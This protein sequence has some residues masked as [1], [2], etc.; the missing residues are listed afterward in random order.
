MTFSPVF[1]CTHFPKLT[2]LPSSWPCL[3]SP[4]PRCLPS[5]DGKFVATLLPSYISIRAVDTLD[6]VRTIKLPAD[7][8]EA[9]TAFVWSSAAKRILISGADEIHVYSATEANFHATI[10]NPSSS[11]AKSTFVD[12][13]ATDHEACVCSA[14]GIR[15]SLFNLASSKVVEISN[16]KFYTASSAARGFSFRPHTR[17]LALLTRTLGKDTVSIH[18]PDSREVQRS[19]S[20]DT[21]DAQGLSWAPDG[22]WLVM[23]E[24]ASQGHRVLFF[25]PDGHK[26][27]D[28]SGPLHP[29]SDDVHTRLAAGVKLVVFS[30][31]SRYLAIGDYGRCISVLPMATMTDQ[32]QLIYPLAVEPQDTVQI[33]QEQ[34]D[35]APNGQ[36]P[37]HKFIRA[38]QPVAPAA[39]A[40]SNAQDIRTGP[41]FMLFDCSATLLVVVLEDA[42]STLWIWDISVSEIR[43]VIM[44]HAEI[45]K[46]EWHPVQAEL[47]LVECEGQDHVGV[48]FAWDPLSE[49]P[50]TVDFKAQLPQGKV[51]GRCSTHWLRN[52]QGPASLF[53]TDSK[54]Y[55]LATVVDVDQDELPWIVR[56]PTSSASL[57]RAAHSPLASAKESDGDDS[58]MDG[59]ASR[60]DDTFQFKKFGAL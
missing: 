1:K 11:I 59:D 39:R 22:K 23:W 15:L 30:P 24:S 31:D 50:R 52:Q 54:S 41:L 34:V 46:L 58:D 10:R 48:A 56:Q 13:G 47:L 3:A 35:H 14:H 16:P 32:L 27:R 2:G 44:F 37:V 42:P 55:A 5:P 60:L 28:W 57:R 19:W 45:S 6:I 38:S 33:W 12:F 17:H 43:A 8:T 36:D 53:F 18:A 26:Y 9:I 25:T 51:C 20:P 40:L 21:V 7:L 49:G 4:S 29:A